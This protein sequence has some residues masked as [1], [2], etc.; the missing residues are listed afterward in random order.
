MA[1]IYDPVKGGV[2]QYHELA[3]LLDNRESTCLLF[4]PLIQ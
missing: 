3:H 4:L 1:W 2:E